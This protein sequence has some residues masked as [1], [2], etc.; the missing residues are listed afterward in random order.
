MRRSEPAVTEE[1]RAGNLVSQPTHANGDSTGR[2]AFRIRK[3]SYSS[4]T[5]PALPL[6][7]PKPVTSRLFESYLA[8][9]TKCYLQFIGEVAT[10]NDFAIWSETRRQSYCSRG[11]HRLKVDHPQTIDGGG[12]NS[13][14][15]KQALWDFAFNQIVRAQHYEVHLHAVQRMRLDDLG[16]SP[17]FIPIRFVPANKL[18]KIDKLTAGFEALVLAKALGAKVGTA[19]IIHGDKGT[20]LKLKTVASSRI[21]NKIIDQIAKLLSSSSPPN[22]N[23]EQALP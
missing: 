9:P 14:S 12:P 1:F 8:C 18:S 2:I 13:H 17:Q 23:L 22:F 21:V 7:M 5:M 15:W 6:D 4:A 20:T 11:I 16:Q 3:I 19:K 10:E